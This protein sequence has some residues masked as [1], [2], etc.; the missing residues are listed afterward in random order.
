M[1]L[2]RDVTVITCTERRGG[3]GDCGRDM[4]LTPNRLPASILVHRTH[5]E[6]GNGEVASWPGSPDPSIH[7]QRPCDESHPHPP[8]IHSL[9]QEHRNTKQ[10][11]EST[12][13][14]EKNVEQERGTRRKNRGMQAQGNAKVHRNERPSLRNSS[15]CYDG[16]GRKEQQN[17]CYDSDKGRNRYWC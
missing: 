1:F 10:E 2:W 9:T 3:R 8:H 12:G 7:T 13:E 15:C 14:C 6:G 5:D 4:S 16:R 17:F 11:S